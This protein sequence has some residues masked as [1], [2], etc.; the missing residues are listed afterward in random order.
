MVQEP[1]QKRLTRAEKVRQVADWL[2]AGYSHPDVLEAVAEA[3]PR[4]KDRRAL[5]ADAFEHIADQVATTAGAR[6]AWHQEARREL[7]RRAL[8][9]MDLK[10]CEAIL[11]DLARLEG[12]YPDRQTRQPQEPPASE[13]PAEDFAA[14]LGIPT[15]Q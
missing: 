14:D 12:L 10:T 3:W 15:I 1:I 4:L 9:L 8:S 7:Y 2:L 11:R 6:R 13:V 5:L